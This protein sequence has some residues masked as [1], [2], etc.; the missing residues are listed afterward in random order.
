MSPNLRKLDWLVE[1]LASFA[2]THGISRK[3]AYEFAS[4]S[5]AL[6][7]I[8]RHYEVEHQLSFEDVL[9]DIEAVSSRN[10]GVL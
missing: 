7:F 3:Q 2:R 9:D 10:G 5:G 8:I 6:D 1:V 4:E